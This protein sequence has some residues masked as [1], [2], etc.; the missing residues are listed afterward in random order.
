MILA[1]IEQEL[2]KV[3][4][5]YFSGVNYHSVACFIIGNVYNLLQY[6]LFNA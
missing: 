5:K 4:F 2:C 1:S 3:I 6:I